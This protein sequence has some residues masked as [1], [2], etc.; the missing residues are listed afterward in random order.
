MKGKSCSW[1]DI[2]RIK[3]ILENAE[4]LKGEMSALTNCVD[5]NTV[6]GWKKTIDVLDSVKSDL[7][8]AH[9]QPTHARAI[10][11]LAPK[12]SWP[13]WVESCVERLRAK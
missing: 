10:A 12:Q 1:R 9:V 7:K 6:R 4:R 2:R 13:E 11:T 8:I 5:A 3:H